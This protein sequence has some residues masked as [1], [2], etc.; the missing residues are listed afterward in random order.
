MNTATCK[1][2][3]E[4]KDRDLFYTYYNG[5]KADKCYP[6]C[7]KCWNIGKYA[8]VGCKFDRLSSEEKL[9]IKQRIDTLLRFGT[10]DHLLQLT[11]CDIMLPA[12]FVLILLLF[13]HIFWIL[14]ALHHGDPFFL[15]ICRIQT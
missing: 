6:K 11:A 8:K 13:L 4:T 15:S 5:A 10:E 12:V 1:L 14:S 9:L 7:I 3:H 2:C